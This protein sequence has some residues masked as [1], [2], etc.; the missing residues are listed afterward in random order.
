MITT[1]QEGWARSSAR[2]AL[3]AAAACLA[4]SAAACDEAK[5]PPQEPLAPDDIVA[6]DVAAA[7]GADPDSAGGDTAVEPDATNAPKDPFVTDPAVPRFDPKRAPRTPEQVAATIEKMKN[8]E[9][10]NE[11][12]V[13]PDVQLASQALSDDVVLTPTSM[14]LPLKGNEAL[15]QLKAGTVIAGNAAQ[16]SRR[17]RVAGDNAFGFMRK[18]KSVKQQ[19]DTV[20]IETEVAKLEN[21]L[22]GSVHL[23]HDASE[24]ADVDTTGVD[25]R[26]YFGDLHKEFGKNTQRRGGWQQT[27]AP[28]GI[29]KEWAL[30]GFKVGGEKKFPIEMEQS[31]D[32]ATVTV[33]G[34]LRV[35]AEAGVEAGVGIGF[36]VDTPVDFWNSTINYMRLYAYGKLWA[37]VGVWLEA[38]TEAKGVVEEKAGEILDK[39]QIDNPFAKQMVAEFTIGE[40][41]PK[42]GPIIT[43]GP[44]IIPTFYLVEVLA[45]CETKVSSSITATA[46]AGL[47][48]EVKFGIEYTKKSGFQP[49]KVM[50]FKKWKEFK[51]GDGSVTAT[52]QCFVGPRMH[53]LVAG[54][55]GPYVDGRAGLRGTLKYSSKCPTPDLLK[56]SQPPTAKVDFLIDIGLK[57]MLGGTIKLGDFYDYSPNVTL[58]EGWWEMYKTTL[59]EGL[60]TPHG[61]CPSNCENGVLD[62]GEG[63]IDCGYVCGGCPV[64][65]KCK[66]NSDC[67]KGHTC[68]EG[69]CSTKDAEDPCNDGK[70]GEGELDVDC[71]GKC[72]KCKSGQKCQ[73]NDQCSSGVCQEATGK[74]STWDCT[75]AFHDVGA[76]TDMDC[77]GNCKLEPWKKSCGVG[78]MCSWDDDCSSGSCFWTGTNGDPSAKTF[79]IP[80]ACAS[81]KDSQISGTETGVNCGGPCADQVKV[82]PKTCWKG[83][84]GA[85][86]FRCPLG[87][88]CITA[89][90]CVS[91]NCIAE[92]GKCGGDKCSDEVKDGDESDV[93]C[94]GSCKQ[95]CAHQKLCNTGADCQEGMVCSNWSKWKNGPDT[96]TRCV[97]IDENG[98]QDVGESDIDCGAKVYTKCSGGQK[99]AG[100]D[101]CAG[102]G[103]GD[104]A[105]LKP[106][107]KPQVC[108]VKGDC[109]DGTKNGLETDVDCGSAC[110]KKCA[111]GANCLQ[112]SDCAA[113]MCAVKE[114]EVLPTGQ[115]VPK[116]GKCMGLC[117]NQIQDPGESAVDCGSSCPAKCPTGVHCN[118]HEDCDSTYCRKPPGSAANWKCAFPTCDDNAIG[119]LETDIDCGGPCKVCKV[120]QMCKKNADCES[121]ACTDGACEP[122]V[123]EN[124]KLDEGEPAVDCGGTCPDKCAEGKACFVDGDCKLAQCQKG[125]CKFDPCQNG[126]KDPA[127]ADLD[128][129]D[130][131][132][133]GPN[134]KC[135][136]CAAGK[137]C[138]ADADCESGMCSTKNVCVADACGDG[139]WSAG[140]G[141]VDCGGTCPDKCAL[142]AT[143]LVHGDCQTGFCSTLKKCGGGYCMDAARCRMPA[144]DDMALN[145]NETDVD[146]GAS[147]NA[148]A[149]GKA[150]KGPADCATGLCVEGKCAPKLCENGL[151]D[152]GEADVDCGGGC[153]P[154]FDGKKCK[155]GSDCE[156]G[157]CLKGGV[158]GYDAC[159][160]GKKD[161]NEADV[162][163]G[164]VCDVVCALGKACLADKGC[165]SGH[166]DGAVCVATACED[167][168]LSPGEAEIDCGAACATKCEVGKACKLPADCA[169]AYCDG[170]KCVATACED[171]K[172]S[173]GE[174]DTDCGGTCAKTCGLKQGCKVGGDCASAVC[175]GSVCVAGSC[176]D[177]KKTDNEGDV[178]C[179]GACEAKCS[180]GAKCV[181][182]DDCASKVCS[183]GGACVLTH[184]D[185]GLL[186][187]DETAIDCGGSCKTKCLLSKGCKADGD[188][189]SGA[190]AVSSQV[191]VSSACYDQ[192]LNKGE[193]D[194][195]CGGPC[196]PCAVGQKCS[197]EADCNSEACQGQPADGESCDLCAPTNTCSNGTCALVKVKCPDDGNV[198]TVEKCAAADGSCSTAPK[199]CDDGNVCSDD[200]CHTTNG[201]VNTAN[202]AK[203]DDNESCTLNDVCANKSCVA[204]PV[205]HGH[206]DDGSKCTV[207]KCTLGKGCGT[208]P[209]SCDDNNVCTA[210]SCQAGSGCVNQTIVS[211][212]DDSN[213]CTN[214]TCHPITGCGHTNNTNPC[215]DSDECTVNESCNGAGSCTKQQKY[216]NDGQD[217]TQDSCNSSSG[218]VYPAKPGGTAC[219]GGAGVCKGTACCSA[220]QTAAF[221]YNG[222]G[223]QDGST[224]MWQVPACATWVVI[225]ARGANGASLPANPSNQGGRGHTAWGSVQGLENKMLYIRI[226]GAG[227][228]LGGYYSGTG[229]IPG[230]YGGGGD[231]APGYGNHGPTGTRGGGGMTT[232]G[233]ESQASMS[234]SLIMAAGGGASN[235][236]TSTYGRTGG[237][238]G[239][240]A[241][242]N[243]VGTGETAGKG[244]FGVSN[245]GPGGYNPTLGYKETT[246]GTYGYD[247]GGGGGGLGWCGVGGGGGGGGQAGG[248]GG[249][250]ACDKVPV[251]CCDSTTS[252]G[253]GGGGRS[254]YRSDLQKTGGKITDYNSNGQNHGNVV[255]KW[256]A[257]PTMP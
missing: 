81:F 48:G 144:C 186:S 179:G 47:K 199:V 43:A 238:G 97:N 214:D 106:A 86:I 217:C 3:W 132:Y 124:Y 56:A 228:A 88:P 109:K 31:V 84:C 13:L 27:R 168:R 60:G 105:C 115:G 111:E 91:G 72:G 107:F 202:G 193:T 20:V 89:G 21:V 123:C 239:Y 102:A 54:V 63:G 251:L 252:A 46:N 71:G 184:C 23:A 35:K 178:D 37:E 2:W 92:T 162:D 14:A 6:G 118:V 166:C 170:S 189:F 122:H 209:V 243:G 26:D 133:Q 119:P 164:G 216:C 38:S 249:V 153:K 232:V 182:G 235:N 116:S 152:A 42:K 236:S 207:D 113:G 242:Q 157:M 96:V 205:D 127:E 194:V 169:S 173:A 137:Q 159:L 167:K 218:C 221:N 185:D 154:C 237:D 136:K 108:V 126:K 145:G 59:W 257:A 128:C 233:L 256:Y 200:S 100:D 220:S 17:R 148:C 85:D 125:I 76:E 227:S 73:G 69:A 110:G 155:Q 172:L 229:A 36:D 40:W 28:W 197:Q 161:S 79:C 241:G 24:A 195:D 190:C 222:S 57:V 171:N 245:P 139:Y 253:G 181:K 52:V 156:N 131:K 16:D 141:G 1:L 149:V 18:V 255:I 34:E 210:D 219:G 98:A 160:N 134:W 188:C 211:K 150:C 19:G 75:N 203:C 112:D 80:Q 138:K 240:P 208:T 58:Y 66:Y 90:D 129:G 250:S 33:D 30:W 29:D 53:W 83:R 213:V 223:G 67:K 225:E 121:K 41:G 32:G 146:C 130:I 49:I 215:P 246:S 4:L 117:S 206:C 5:L 15:L 64:G 9:E 142:N 196:K 147:C 68:F 55:V 50:E 140:E 151:L 77:G 234:S 101:D 177:G 11:V 175:N 224:Q 120:G 12:E 61:K 45:E 174:T 62:V 8:G 158:C 165:A 25:V 44:V 7:D 95:K 94:G 191:C 78:K 244:A 192:Q 247:G 135:A 187:G 104:L 230:F 39:L 93:D 176:W 231:A 226:G 204:G 248:G 65:T 254:Y 103:K 82:S 212:C 114:I 183:A 70:L 87:Q 143:C 201:C 10:F 51:L 74:C 198:C 163:C 180:T 22:T 99:C